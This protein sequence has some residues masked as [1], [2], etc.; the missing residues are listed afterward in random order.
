MKGE[1]RL[2]GE[3]GGLNSRFALTRWAD[4]PQVG[5]SKGVCYES[6][7]SRQRI[8]CWAG[9]D[10]IKS[11]NLTDWGFVLFMEQ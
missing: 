7:V 11:L 4:I 9:T 1:K 10:C 5:N 8:I 3:L 2:C 6:V